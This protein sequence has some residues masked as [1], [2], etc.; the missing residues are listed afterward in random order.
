M[1]SRTR[2]SARTS[3][4]DHPAIGRTI[5][6]TIDEVGRNGDGIGRFEGAPVFVP[7]TLPGDALTVRLSSRRGQGFAAD[8]V[9]ERT[10]MPRSQPVCRHFGACGGCRLQHVPL[11]D[12]RQW[13]QQQIETVL[14]VR[15]IQDAVILPLIDGDLAARR[16][17]RTAFR[18]EG[19]GL[20]LGFRRRLGRAVVTIEDCP[21]ADPA[22]IQLFTP[23]RRSLA[24]LDMAVKG[25]ELSI[26]VAENGLDL[27]IETPV[28]PGLA[29]REILAGLAETEDLARLAWRGD[30]WA[31]TEPIAV[32]RQPVVDFGGIPAAFP[33]GAFLQATRKA[34]NAIRHAAAK[35]IGG[36]ATIADLFAG[37]G[38]LSLPFAK[39]GRRVRA[40]E[41][42]P[43]MVQ[44]LAVAASAAGLASKVDAIIRDLDGE[45][46]SGD[47][48]G[49]FEGLIID[50][51]R[52]GA[53][54]Q[55]EAIAAVSGPKRI[56]M[57]SC[58]P[59][60]FARDARTLVDAGYRLAWVQP[61][62]AFLYAAE[63]EL[64]GAFES[65]IA[66]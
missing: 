44:A 14:A 54:A 66:S 5:A 26:T 63:I 40:V 10:L 19:Q 2:R 38:A 7:L 33:I 64:V 53:R 37:C 6:L 58:N 51:P 60:T 12:Y 36:A 29:D 20:A 23:L 34:E 57:V 52:A 56:A 18:L 1:R 59:A 47:E 65:T 55:V 35:A 62:D 50:P 46:L 49:Q 61:I 9:E 39:E 31:S 15:G 48:L 30:M 8:V 24:S 11:L 17:L 13:K 42:D 45:P 21:I 32:R 16:R 43:A 3:K 27:L 41:R 22:I 25:G 28:P 4:K